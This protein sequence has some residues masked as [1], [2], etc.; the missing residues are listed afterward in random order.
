MIESYTFGKIVVAGK[1]YTHDIKIIHGEV[2]PEWW[3][4]S[5]H[6]LVIHDIS[7]FLE[8]SPDV[9]VIGCGHSGM[10]K[11]EPAVRDA[12]AKA[13]IQLIDDRSAEAVRIFNRRHGRGENVAAGFHLTC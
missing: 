6:R 5:G 10:M 2:I 7:D 4:K 12:L 13:R 3:R 1:T 8:A 9:L 11:I